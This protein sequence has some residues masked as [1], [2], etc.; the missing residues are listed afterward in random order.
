MSAPVG[1]GKTTL[2][3]MLAK[4]FPSLVLSVSSTTRPSR[5]FEQEGRDYHFL[6][7]EEFEKQILAG[8]FLEYAEVFGNYYGTS[9]KSLEK[10]RSSGKHVLLVIDTQGALQLKERIDAVYIFIA[11]P[12]FQELQRRLEA[13]E[14]ESGEEIQKRLSWAHQEMAEIDQY[15]YLIVNDTLDN[16]YA[17][18][19]SILIA[20]EHR[21]Y[22]KTH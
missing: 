22:A 20:E 19:R 15:D 8:E 4:E 13:R 12:N 18:L 16:A 14:S 11:P 3:R 21:V 2:A 5:S 17:V 6:S 7:R 1:T 9:K 10:M